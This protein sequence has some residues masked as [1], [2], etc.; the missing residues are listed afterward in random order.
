VLPNPYTS[1]KSVIGSAIAS[2]I[3]P[4]DKGK[5]A[6]SKETAKKKEVTPI[7][8]DVYAEYNRAQAEFVAALMNI[9]VEH[10]K[11]NWD[12]TVVYVSVRCF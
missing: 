4:I 7:L 1:A 10:R 3:N 2:G 8:D 9:P 11:D 6:L 5:S 12:G